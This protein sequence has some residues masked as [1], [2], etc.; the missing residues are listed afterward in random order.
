MANLFRGLLILGFI[1]TLISKET[2]DLGT[3]ANYLHIY[4]THLVDFDTCKG[5]DH[6]NY[7]D[8]Y[9]EPP[10]DECHVSQLEEEG[11]NLDN[12][13]SCCPS[14]STYMGIASCEGVDKD[15]RPVDFS[16]VDLCASHKEVLGKSEEEL[17]MVK[18]HPLSPIDCPKHCD[19]ERGLLD[20]SQL[21]NHLVNSTGHGIQLSVDSQNFTK[22][23]M[24]RACSQIG[25]SGNTTTKHVAGA[26]LAA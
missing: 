8:E 6:F 13:K 17:E 12:V 21:T 10:E 4:G 1:K 19:L 25:D 11:S 22:F 3:N 23:C 2:I 26:T 9:G 16:N 18:L 15:G 7:L 20:R 24:A 14:P 5:F